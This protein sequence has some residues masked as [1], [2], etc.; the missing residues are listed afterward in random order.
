MADIF[1][2]LKGY[3]MQLIDRYFAGFDRERFALT[4]I[5]LDLIL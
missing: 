4:F 1:N 3:L 5:I 2:Q